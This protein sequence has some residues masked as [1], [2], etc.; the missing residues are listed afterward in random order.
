MT[1]RPAFGA[2]PPPGVAIEDFYVLRLYVIAGTPTSGRA[3]VNVRRFCEQHLGGRYVLEILDIAE[4]VAQAA[5]DE[6]VAA[7]TLVKL[8]PPPLRRFIGDLSRAE[9]LLQ[10]LH[11]R[12]PAALATEQRP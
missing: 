9:R 1:L 10:G 4:H 8:G 5:V 7:P 2:R 11:L 3:V 12:P 6:I